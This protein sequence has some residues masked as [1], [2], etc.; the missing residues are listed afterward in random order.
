L[1][2]RGPR[3]G[4]RGGGVRCSCWHAAVRPGS[5]AAKTSG[6]R[7][8]QGHGT[9]EA[10]AAVRARP[11]TLRNSGYPAAPAPGR[12]SPWPPASLFRHGM[13]G[14]SATEQLARSHATLPYARRPPVHSRRLPPQRTN[15]CFDLARLLFLPARSCPVSARA[16]RA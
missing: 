1:A 14:C 4:V 6:H 3:P 13:G 12:Q 7:G 16:S 9:R 2:G 10:K 15:L 8:P 11:R 5:P